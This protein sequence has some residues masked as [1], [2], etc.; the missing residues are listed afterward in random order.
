[1]K[2]ANLQFGLSTLHAWI[3]F[4][5]CYLYLS[6]KLDIKKW[7]A[8]SAEEK[9]KTQT[10]TNNVKKSFCLQLG[11]IIDQPKP[12]FGTTNDGNTAR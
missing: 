2:E 11:L 3:R 10:R 8:R 1:M 7:Q 4:L 12:D 5:E 9:E 6:Y